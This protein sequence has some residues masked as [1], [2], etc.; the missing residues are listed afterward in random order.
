LSN[1]NAQ[2]G[3]EKWLKKQ[4][5]AHVD[6]ISGYEKELLQKVLLNMVD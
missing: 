4:K 5:L 6:Y 1:F 3:V 2:K